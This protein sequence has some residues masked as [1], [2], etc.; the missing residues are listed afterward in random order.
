MGLAFVRRRKSIKKAFHPQRGT[1]DKQFRG[2]T[3]I[4]HITMPHFFRIQ[5]YP[6]PVTEEFRRRL[7]KRM[8]SAPQLKRELRRAGVCVRFQSSR[9]LPES[10][11][12]NDYF[13]LSS[14]CAI[15]VLI[16]LPEFPLVNVKI[17]AVL[18]SVLFCLFRRRGKRLCLSGKRWHI[19]DRQ[20]IECNR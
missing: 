7:L 12:W 2:T 1:K 20:G 15:F 9:T 5:Q 19:A 18:F 14:L 8:V 11:A 17:P 4:R 6:I 10:R 13:P 3:H 16:I